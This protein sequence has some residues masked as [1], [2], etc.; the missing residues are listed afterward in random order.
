MRTNAAID[1]RDQPLKGERMLNAF[2]QNAFLPMREKAARIPR[3][4]FISAIRLP[5]ARCS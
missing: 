3:A 5:S 4:A 1:Q 2:S